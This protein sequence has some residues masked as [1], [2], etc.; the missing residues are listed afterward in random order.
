MKR[1]ILFA[2]LA[3]YSMLGQAYAGTAAGFDIVA[4][5]R[6]NTDGSLSGA[7]FAATLI[8]EG[9]LT[10]ETANFTK[11]AVSTTRSIYTLMS[12]ERSA[13]VTYDD[14]ISLSLTISDTTGNTFNE[15]IAW[16]AAPTPVQ[17]TNPQFAG[18]SAI[19]NANNY[20]KY[21]ASGTFNTFIDDLDATNI[22][23]GVETNTGFS[24]RA[25][26][27]AGAT[28]VYPVTQS[29]NFTIDFRFRLSG[30]ITDSLDMETGLCKN[31]DLSSAVA[32]QINSINGN[33]KFFTYNES[34]ARS[35]PVTSL[36]GQLVSNTEW[37][38]GKLTFENNTLS[39]LVGNQNYGS[40]SV[41]PTSTGRYVYWGSQNDR[42]VIDGITVAG[43]ETIITTPKPSVPGTTTIPRTS[44]NA[45][46]RFS[47]TG[48]IEF[49]DGD[50]I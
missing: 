6:D 18:T 36:T 19:G 29:G 13:T 44:G 28:I 34:G 7:T 45:K 15:V 46:I 27:R 12:G 39:L 17:P 32:F 16:T 8:V 31:T 42:F 48:T 24:A 2:F 4:D 20:T 26:N 35:T 22:M 47:G 41:P 40:Y 43:N 30:T 5:L 38:D 9:N 10:T 11:S 3:F 25:T 37:H 14:A 23:F 33:S 49:I 1:I 50:L 21:P